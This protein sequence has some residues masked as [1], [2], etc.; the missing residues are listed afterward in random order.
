VKKNKSASFKVENNG[1]SNL[2]I[3]SLIIGPDASMFKLTGGNKTVKPGKLSTIKVT[4]KPT[5]TG[6]KQAT[7][8]IT[9][10]D[11]DTSTIDIPLTGTGQ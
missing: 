2:S 3:V 11:P 8:R 1:E 6:S 9:S 4:F 5:S 10:N 7:L